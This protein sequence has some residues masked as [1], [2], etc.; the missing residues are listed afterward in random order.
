[1]RRSAQLDL[2]LHKQ[3]VHP[4]YVV[5]PTRTGS[6]SVQS[7]ALRFLDAIVS[8]VALLIGLCWLSRPERVMQMFP[9]V[10]LRS[11]FSGSQDV[12]EAECLGCLHIAA[13]EPGSQCEL[14]ERH[15]RRHLASI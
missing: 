14:W 5:A 1:M 6:Y 15:V 7:F 3:A 13:A 10:P 9:Q 12:F 8:V 11:F 4:R 2:N